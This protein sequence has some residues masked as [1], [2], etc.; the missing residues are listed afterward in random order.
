[1]PVPF[2]NR[3]DAGQQLASHLSQYRDRSDVIVLGLPRGGIPV[4]A[5]VAA[6]LNAPLD[7]FL[8]R[9]LGVPGHEELAMGAIASGGLRVLNEDTVRELHIPAAAIDAVEAN[10]LRELAR[11]ERLYR[12]SQAPPDITGQTVI[13]VDDGLA[14]GSTLRAGALALREGNPAWLV[15]AVPVA[16]RTVC[17]AMRNVVDEMVC[18]ETPEPFYAVGLWYDD[19]GQTTDDEVRRHLA[20]AERRLATPRLD[21]P[22]DSSTTVPAPST[23]SE[24]VAHAALPLRGEAA[25]IDPLL[26]RLEGAEIVLI[27]EA[28]HGTHEFYAQRADI[29]RRLIVERGFNAVAVEADWPDAYRINCFVRGESDDPDAETALGDFHRFPRWMWRNED[30][31]EFVRWLREYNDALPPGKP[32]TGFYGIDLYSL[33]RSIEAV[34]AYLDKVDPDAAARA[35]ARYG[36]FE[37]F[38]DNPQVYGQMVSLGLA[39]D[40]ENEVVGQLLELQQRAAELRGRDGR[41]GVDEQF[42]AEQN[43][44]VARNA[45][46]YYRAMFRGRVSSWNL[47]DQHMADTIDSLIP[48]LR[49]QDGHARIAVWAHNSHLGDARA[50]EMGVVGEQN[51]GQLMR[52]RHRDET[53]GIGFTTYEGT[54]AA[55]T[56]WDSPA[57]RRHVLP[58]LPGSYEDLLHQASAIAETDLMLDLRNPG[59]VTETLAEPRLERAIGVIYKPETERFSHY[60]HAILPRQFD[61]VLHIDR[62]SAVQPIDADPGFEAPDETPETWPFG[63]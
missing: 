30:V 22:T 62:T 14:T 58:A 44:R 5:E 9:K 24:A 12:G 50:T 63:V 19:F 60:F 45:A 11:R 53:Y 18:A 31:L 20:R 41:S 36:C 25:D 34:I 2:R 42:F 46:A 52:E 49:E 27:G 47:R 8:V 59:G 43:A 17:D 26:Q 33:S 55:A 32:K 15:G 21:Q 16:S 38:G 35:R 57:R 54:V 61:T 10:E 48:H 39:E 7:A 4:A 40:C 28:S 56:E 51:V 13:L 6:A 37:D 29:T 3:A 23:P 1:M